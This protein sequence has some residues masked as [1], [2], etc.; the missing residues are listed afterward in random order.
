MLSVD[1]TTLPL[2]REVEGCGMEE[3]LCSLRTNKEDEEEAEALLLTS[4]FADE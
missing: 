4:L 2:S 1:E 3:L